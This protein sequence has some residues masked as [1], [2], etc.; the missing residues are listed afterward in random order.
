MIHYELTCPHCKAP[1]DFSDVNDKGVIC[2]HQC[3][4]DFQAKV[5]LTF[6]H[7]HQTGGVT[8]DE[9][10]K[11]AVAFRTRML[12]DAGYEYSMQDSVDHMIDAA[13]EYAQG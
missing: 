12:R 9:I 13:V 5:E 2:C 8:E 1:G 6:K 11:R 3:G 4:R 10:Y 7:L